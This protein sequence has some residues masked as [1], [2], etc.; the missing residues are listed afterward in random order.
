M[1]AT[2]IAGERTGRHFVGDSHGGEIVQG[3][4]P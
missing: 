1:K 2:P 3:V 4:S